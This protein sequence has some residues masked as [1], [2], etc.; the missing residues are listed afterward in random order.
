M[1]DGL[2][3]LRTAVDKEDE[4]WIGL[5]LKENNV[6]RHNGNS[7]EINQMLDDCLKIELERIEARIEREHSPQRIKKEERNT[8]LKLLEGGATPHDMTSTLTKILGIELANAQQDINLRTMS[9]EKRNDILTL[10][11][12]GA[13]PADA[14]KSFIAKLESIREYERRHPPK[15]THR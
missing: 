3:Q 7:A 1:S 10:V 5:I 12:G 4:I 2:D 9:R 13:K 15:E 14:A 11:E 8:I 6:H